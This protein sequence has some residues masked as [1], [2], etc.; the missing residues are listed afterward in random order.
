ME[1][2]WDERPIIG[3]LLG[4]AVGDALGLPFENFSARRRKK[5]FND[6]GEHRFLLG[7]GMLSDDTE[8][9]CM[10][11]QAIIGS[12]GQEELFRQQ[13]AWKLRWWLWGLPVGIGRATL[14]SLIKLWL[15]FRE[16]VFSAGNG[17]AMRSSLLGA[18]F[19]NDRSKL[20][21]LVRISTQL[22][23]VDPKA[24]HGA[25]AVALAAHLSSSTL[26]SSL[27]AQRFCTEL[28]A[29]LGERGPKFR[30]LVTQAKESADRGESATNFAE[31]LGLARGVTGYV[32][33]TVPVVLQVWFRHPDAYES[34]LI[35]VIEAGGD[36][37]TTGAILGG[38]LGARVGT[39]G[40]P[41]RW[42]NGLADWPRT[43]RWMAQ[44]GHTVTKS[45]AQRLT[46]PRLPIWGLALRNLFFFLIVLL[47][48]L[49]R[50]LPPY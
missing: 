43:T 30:G 3:C 38:I 34:A 14:K 26:E 31:H 48:V 37:D 36:T 15:G 9:L 6:V 17:P 46:P 20:A 49:R 1:A 24:E 35:D 5:L 8:H 7:R 41:E 40:I 44:L 50:M 10:V 19:G 45:Q 23:H 42:L 47:H 25:F 18:C 2:R 27:M 39:E 28:F 4:T 33:H 12:Q 11:A 21:N 29:Q 22:T 13:L 32:Y 16:G